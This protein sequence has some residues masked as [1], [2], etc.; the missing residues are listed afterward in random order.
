MT[1]KPGTAIGVYSTDMGLEHTFVELKLAG[2]PVEDIS[3]VFLSR[4]DSINPGLVKD[5]E[6]TQQPK[7]AA[8]TR[9]LNST[10]HDTLKWLVSIGTKAVLN[11]SMII[12]TGR[13]VPAL[14][15]KD[16][17]GVGELTEALVSQGIQQASARYCEKR[18][19]NGGFLISIDPNG[20]DGIELATALL[21]K[22]RAEQVWTQ[23]RRFPQ[24]TF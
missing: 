2:F 3:V 19:R 7:P 8:Q 21:E 23:T 24:S 13:F 5:R 15:T 12:A 14:A 10:G 6:E 22:T 4:G 20:R 1:R 9:S 16:G 17:R 11:R 18:V